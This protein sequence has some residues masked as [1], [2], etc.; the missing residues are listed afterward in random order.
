MALARAAPRHGLAIPDDL[1]V[2]SIGSAPIDK[3]SGRHLTGM[4]PDFDR[5]IEMCLMVL[6]RQVEAGRCDFS[7]AFMRMHYHPGHT[8]AAIN[9]ATLVEQAASPRLRHDI[10]ALSRTVE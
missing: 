1:S 2:V 3:K 5:M 9:G 10:E 7:Q 4:L 8:L 6:D